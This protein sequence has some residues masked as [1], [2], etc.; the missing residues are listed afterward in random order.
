MIQSEIQSLSLSALIELFTLDLSL[1]GGPGLNFHAGTNSLLGDV[2]WSGQT[3]TRFPVIAEGFKQSMTGAQP[4]PI[5]TAS[6]IQGA[7]G[8]LARSY[9]DFAGC[10]LTRLRTFARFLDAAN[11]TTN[12]RPSLEIVRVFLLSV[13]LSNA[14]TK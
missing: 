6:N 2:I 7:L 5:L 11:F 1:Q 3:Y 14:S 8:A 9:S 4:R 12:K 13:S 10:K